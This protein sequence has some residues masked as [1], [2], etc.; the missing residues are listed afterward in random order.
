MS[1]LNLL[2]SSDPQDDP[3]FQA[4]VKRQQAGYDSYSFNRDPAIKLLSVYFGEKVTY[5]AS[6]LLSSYRSFWSCRDINISFFLRSSFNPLTWNC[7]HSAYNA[8]VV[9][10]FFLLLSLW[11]FFCS[12]GANEWLRNFFFPLPRS[13]ERTNH[14]KHS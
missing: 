7:K 2:E 3:S 12:S 13:N 1:Y 8:Q 6:F 5:H 14:S 4:N 10:F 9:Y 11:V